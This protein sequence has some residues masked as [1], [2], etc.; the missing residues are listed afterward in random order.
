MAFPLPSGTGGRKG[1]GY[2]RQL[3]SL[4]AANAHSKELLGLGQRLFPLFALALDLPETFFDDKTRHP[5]AIMRLLFYPGLDGREVDEL[6]PGIGDHTGK[7]TLPC[8]L[9]SV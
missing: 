8:I 1:E 3:A 9:P 6:M 7:S 2:R 5:A 4:A